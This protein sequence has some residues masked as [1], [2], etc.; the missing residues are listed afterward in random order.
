MQK[1]QERDWDKELAEVDRL[2][3]QLPSHREEQ[4]AAQASKRA[5]P[6]ARPGPSPSDLG[7]GRIGTWARVGLGLLLGI[8]MP[9][10]PYDHA[11]GIKLFIYLG[12]VL[13][14]VVAGVWSSLSSWKRR[15]GTAHLISQLLVVWGLVLTAEVLL[16]RMGYAK[17]PATWFCP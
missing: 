14:V 3:N 6:A 2:L 9:L 12:G 8:G 7:G 11:C 15:M 17:T 10:W 4:V 5:Q 1:N 13:T 16:P